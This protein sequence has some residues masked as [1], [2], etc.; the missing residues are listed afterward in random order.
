MSP[1]PYFAAQALY[2]IAGQRRH[3]SEWRCGKAERCAVPPVPC[4]KSIVS[5]LGCPAAAAFAGHRR[6]VVQLHP[7]VPFA[8]VA[9]L[10]FALAPS[11]AS[12]RTRGNASY[13]VVELDRWPSFGAFADEGANFFALIRWVSPGVVCGHPAK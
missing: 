13:L 9:R 4:T 1:L 5:P 12:G 7:Q 8:L 11:P 2:G 10:R 3:G 6:P